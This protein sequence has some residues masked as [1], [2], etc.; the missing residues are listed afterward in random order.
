[1]SL[2][3]FAKIFFVIFLFLGIFYFIF[4]K[5][6][7]TKEVK[8]LQNEDEDI[9]Y[10]SNILKDIEYKTKDK[11]GNEYLIRALKGEI[12]FSNAATSLSNTLS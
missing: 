10:N 6:F 11:D 2:K 12:D 9:S 1:M 5:Y 7:K 3:K 4:S 8:D